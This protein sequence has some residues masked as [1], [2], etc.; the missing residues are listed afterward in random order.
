MQARRFLGLLLL[1][2]VLGTTGVR[3]LS[4]QGLTIFVQFSDGT[5][6]W[7]GT[8]LVT[9]RG[10]WVEMTACSFGMANPVTY[11]G[12]GGV[13]GRTQF[14]DI[15]LTKGVDK[16][17]PAIFASLVSGGGVIPANSQ[18]ANVTIEFTTGSPGTLLFRVELKDVYF[19]GLSSGGAMGDSRIF[20]S[21]SMAMGSVRIT[22][23][24]NGVAGAP[25]SWSIVTNSASF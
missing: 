20:E 11:T 21:V 17:T 19:T 12:S 24:N 18:G 8:S 2:L 16:L 6:Q 1:G 9:G 13:G 10:S 4:A 22:Q 7:A 15:T 23:F 5:G 14:S 25:K 3:S